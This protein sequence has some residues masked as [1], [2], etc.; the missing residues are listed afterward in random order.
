MAHGKSAP[1]IRRAGDRAVV[2]RPQQ[3]RFHFWAVSLHPQTL[4]G[5][6]SSS[7][8]SGGSPASCCHSRY[9]DG[10]VAQ[11]VVS[12][13]LDQRGSKSAGWSWRHIVPFPV[14]GFPRSAEAEGGLVLPPLLAVPLAVTSCWQPFRA[15]VDSG[16]NWATAA[17]GANHATL[18]G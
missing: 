5:S 13:N 11:E 6:S 7:L 1:C 8:G 10:W 16:V 3:P 12:P 4:Q 18:P 2:R 15:A 9:M 17:A 14:E